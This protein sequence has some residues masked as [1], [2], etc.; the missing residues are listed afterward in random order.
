MKSTTGNIPIEKTIPKV[1]PPII[2]DVRKN[3]AA[4]QNKNVL[5]K[6]VKPF[7]IGIPGTKNNAQAIIGCQGV[8]VGKKCAKYAAVVAV[9]AAKAMQT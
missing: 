9:N 2:N 8:S 6:S 3:L 7:I 4:P 1:I 5:S